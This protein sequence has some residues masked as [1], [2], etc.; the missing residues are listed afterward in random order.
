MTITD[1]ARRPSRRH[2]GRGSG[3]TSSTIRSAVGDKLRD[4]RETRGLDLH[5]VERDTKIRIKFLAALEDGEFT[6]LPGDVYARGF[7]RNYATYLGLDADEMEE[8]WREEAGSAT[9]A[10]PTFVGPQP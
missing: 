8:Q 2:I 3:G 5:R 6:E 10:L 4:A 7:L 1:P 9:P